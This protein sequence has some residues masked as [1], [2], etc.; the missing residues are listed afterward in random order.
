MKIAI[1]G[2]TGFIGRHL[3]KYFLERKYSLILI[4][5]NRK[6]SSHSLIRNA[7]WAELKSDVRVLE[8]VDAIVNLAGETINQR[9]TNAAKERILQ[10]RL[11]TVKQIADIV[12]RMEKK[13]QVV[14]N[15]SG[16]SIYGTSETKTFVEHSDP[17]VS[18][19]L[20]G[21]VAQWEQA[22]DSIPDTRIVKL[23]LGIVLGMDGGAF[24]KMML[25]YKLGIGGR[26]GSGRQVLSWIHI[27]DLCRLIEFCIENEDIIEQ[28]N[29]T[30]PQP[31]TNDE[32]GR[33]LAKAMNTSHRFPVPAFMMKLM[34]GELSTLLLEGQRAL[35][36]LATEYEFHFQYPVLESALRDLLGSAKQLK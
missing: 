26:I 25:P 31:V 8:G 23:R 33:A 16:I 4:S 22:M 9:W 35:P 3:I 19:F 6:P 29:A 30:A 24:P 13:P 20:S 5:R 28:I 15:A 34:F 10:S 36:Y 14:V 11:D 21:V 1:A 32:F 2:G 18:D 17:N 12:S 7:T 27:H